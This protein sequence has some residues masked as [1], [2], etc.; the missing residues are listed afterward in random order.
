MLIVSL[1]CASLDPYECHIAAG[2]NS[3]VIQLWQVDQH[4][5]RGKNLYNRFSK[6]YCRWELNN[7]TL[8][9]DEMLLNIKRLH[10]DEDQQETYY[11]DQYFSKKYEDN[12]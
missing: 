8:D 7:F 2:F 12:S 11:R 4:S 6:T 10:R 9:E 3:S 5:T 1:S